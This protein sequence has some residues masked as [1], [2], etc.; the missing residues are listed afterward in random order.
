MKIGVITFWQTKNNYGQILQCFALQRVLVNWGHSP[1]LI[2]YTH[3]EI[4]FKNLRSKMKDLI[5]KV[6]VRK[7]KT[8]KNIQMNDDVRNFI[9]FKS[10]N[11]IFSNNIYHSI[12]ELRRNPPEA[13][14]YITG[15]D[16]VW[17]KS[18]AFDENRT[19]FLDF[20]SNKTKRIS[21]AASFAMDRYDPKYTTILKKLL[22]KFNRISTR[23]QNGVEICSSININA[24]KVLDP[25]MLLTAVDY[26]N[27]FK[28][29]KCD[30]KMIFI[31]SLNI[32]SPSEIHWSEIKALSIEDGLHI[33]ITPSSGYFTCSDIFGNEDYDYATIPHWLENIANAKLVVTTSFHGIVFCI[34]FHTPFVYVPLEGIWAKGN[35]RAID[36]LTSLSLIDRCL[37]RDSCLS[38]ISKKEIDWSF[39]DEKLFEMRKNSLMFLK[40]A[41]YEK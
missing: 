21:Y 35:S 7:E 9:S 16:Q 3:S 8:T 15:S 13:D 32:S 1:F 27:Y 39:V 33:K 4:K 19:F 23:E 2:R 38:E 25:T 34:L 31:Y 22:S 20:G 30:S 14:I 26:I 28:L 41:I 17:S 37:Y 29:K 10:R 12:K 18:L 5:S 11:L 36:L 40:Q 24:T 6:F